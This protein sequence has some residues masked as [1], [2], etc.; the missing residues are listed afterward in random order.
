MVDLSRRLEPSQAPTDHPIHAASER[1]DVRRVR[2]FLDADPSLISDI[3]RAG[4]HPLHRAVVGRAH[5]VVSLLLDRGADI[6]AIHGAG[7]GSASGYAPQD[8]QPIDLSIWGGPWQVPMSLATKWRCFV[9]M[10]RR[11]VRGRRRWDG[12]AVPYDARLARLLIDRGATF[13]L[14]IASALG[15]LDAVRAMLDANPSRISEQRPDDRRPLYAAAEFGRLDILRLLLDRGADPTWPD[16]EFSERGAA[17]HAASRAGN[18]EMVKLLLQHG[19]DPNGFNDAAG[20]AVFVAGTPEIR[21]LLEAHGGY[22]DP[23]DLVWK[24]EDDEVM[25]VVT[26][27][28]ETA[29]A[30]CGGVFPAVVTCGRRALMHRLLDAG[31][32]VH[33]QA[34]GCHSYLLEQPDM[35]TVLLQ[36]GGLDPDYP[37]SDGVTLLHELCHRDV[38]GRTMGHRIECATILLDAGA[39]LSPRTN[40]GDTPL[41]WAMKH[42]LADM[43][44]FLTERGAV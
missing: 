4:G 34:G 8:L 20:N 28:P 22:L 42:G 41:A 18:L 35:L 13:D 10:L 2:G 7:A 1:G 37:T 11:V 44:A 40:A 25:R 5:A 38:R 3:N 24:G 21:K 32:K 43:V 29:L 31:I 33:P 26:M 6:H 19:A 17:L 14:T 39:M 27:K 30:G 15:D 9:G 16:A 36:R 23:F 12:H